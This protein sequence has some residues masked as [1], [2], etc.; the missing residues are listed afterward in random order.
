M[1]SSSVWA[2]VW[3]DSTL[4]CSFQLLS[5]FFFNDTICHQKYIYVFY[6][7]NRQVCFILFVGNGR[8]GVGC[9]YLILI[10][11]TWLETLPLKNLHQCH[12]TGTAGESHKSSEIKSLTI[13]TSWTIAWGHGTNQSCSGTWKK[14]KSCNKDKCRAAAAAATKYTKEKKN[15]DWK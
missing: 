1:T 9:T 8:G 12:Y 10:N 14:E 5:L 3:A 7:F 15:I 4:P 2:E 6:I 13:E 11:S